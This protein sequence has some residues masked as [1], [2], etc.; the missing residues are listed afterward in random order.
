MRRR[1]MALHCSSR[2]V[3]EFE[4]EVMSV[5]CFLRTN[6]DFRRP[7][8][9]GV[10]AAQHPKCTQQADRRGHRGSDLQRVKDRAYILFAQS[11]S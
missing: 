4:S 6:S 1:S 2:L 3:I 11:K 9:D 7:Q 10:D 8:I 5:F